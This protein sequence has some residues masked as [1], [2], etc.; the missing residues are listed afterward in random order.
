MQIIKDYAQKIANINQMAHITLITYQE[1]ADHMPIAI[2][3]TH[4]DSMHH[5][6]AVVHVACS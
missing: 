3:V 4:T 6:L 5:I 1:Y 2:T